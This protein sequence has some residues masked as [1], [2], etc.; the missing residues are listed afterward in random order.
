V[1][2]TRGKPA[3]VPWAGGPELRGSPST[4]DIEGSIRED[5]SVIRATLPDAPPRDDS[6]DFFD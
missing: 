2:V 6:A 3:S 1:V 5:G 4:D